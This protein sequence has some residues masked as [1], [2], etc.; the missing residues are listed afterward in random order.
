MLSFVGKGLNRI[1]G[2]WAKLHNKVL[3]DLFE[4]SFFFSAILIYHKA[5]SRLSQTI[6]TFVNQ[7]KI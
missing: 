1:I 6:L 5:N 2:P 3:I 4:Q 7:F